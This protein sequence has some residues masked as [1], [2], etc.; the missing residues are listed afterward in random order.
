MNGNY[1]ISLPDNNYTVRSEAIPGFHLTTTPAVYSVN[2]TGTDISNVDFGYFLDIPHDYE[3]E[4]FITSQIPRCNAIVP[5]TLSILNTGIRNAS[6]I[7]AF[8]KDPLMTI[9][10]AVPMYDSVSGNNY[11][12]HYTNLLPF[13][14]QDLVALNILMPGGGNTVNSFSAANALDSLGNTL[15]TTTNILSQ[16]IRCSMDPNL[17]TASPSD[18]VFSD[19]NAYIT[20]T[21]YFQNTGNDTAFNVRLI[22]TLDVLLDPTTFEVIESS[23]SYNVQMEAGNVVSFIFDNILLPDSNVNLA[24]SEGHVTYR[25]R[26]LEVVPDFSIVQNTACIYFDSNPPI[27]T[28]TTTSTIHE[29][30]VGVINLSTDNFEISAFPNPS[31][32]DIHIKLSSIN[33]SNKYTAELFDVNGK[34]VQKYENMRSSEFT[35]SEENLL[36]GKYILRVTDSEKKTNSIKLV[37]K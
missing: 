34:V 3:I 37:I 33:I 9:I 31:Y 19:P 14:R 28:N 11:Y 26:P 24:G 2:T 29:A 23:H 10:S 25:I 27:N 16:I 5:Y 18:N 17:K 6:G 13:A 22:D 8:E 35:I 1:S 15:D 36:S 4:T 21:I 30:T 32:S 12:W 20:Y 7:F